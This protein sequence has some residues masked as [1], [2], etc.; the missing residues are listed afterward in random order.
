M[1]SSNFSNG[2]VKTIG[3][4]TVGPDYQVSCWIQPQNNWDNETNKPKPITTEQ[5]NQI[6]EIVDLM[7]KNNFQMS[8]NIR[9]RN[10]GPARGWIDKMKF[11]MFNNSDD[12][13]PGQSSAAPKTQGEK[14]GF[15]G[16]R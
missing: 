11:K 2:R 10:E 5:Y 9:E 8:V 3:N 13:T 16:K 1:A 14:V 7:I 15:P 12:L 4:M 6:N